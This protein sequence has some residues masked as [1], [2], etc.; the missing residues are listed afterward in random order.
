MSTIPQKRE[1]STEKVAAAQ[2]SP[3]WLL[4]GASLRNMF[5]ELRV[6]KS[7]PGS[8]LMAN[9]T[10]A[11]EMFRKRG[12]RALLIILSIFIGVSAVMV[13]I[14]W[15]QGL[16]ASLTNQLLGLG[17]NVITV[18]PGTPNTG[19][20][21]NISRP[22][23]PSDAQS[24]QALPHVMEVSPIITVPSVQVIYGNRNWNTDTE[25]V[26]PDFQVIQ[27]WQAG[28]GAWFGPLE[29]D[30][31]EAVAV[32]G[33]TV[34]HQLFTVP[35]SN[36]IGQQ[37]RIRDRP[38]RVIGILASKGA[39]ASQD[40]V[41]FVPFHTALTYLRN[42]NTVDHIE[43]Q[44]DTIDNIDQV[45]QGITA[46][47]R[48]NHHIAQGRADDFTIVTAGD[49]IQS[50]QQQ[51]QLMTALSIGIAAISL[52]IAGFGIT[53]TMFVAVKERTREIGIRMSIGARRRNIRNQ[54]LI[55]ALAV[56]L[57]GGLAGLLLGLL[58]G[59]IVTFVNR[60]PFV[61]TPTTVLLPFAISSALALIFGLYPARRA[62][63]L[64]PINAI[65]SSF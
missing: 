53:N 58:I 50:T 65:R 10:D 48:Q 15:T 60:L 17:A 16:S 45:Q 64:D 7:K 6:R 32:L 43:I 5:Q 12:T 26:S 47:L 51:T 61:V 59:W 63:R 29:D 54:F 37:I 24:L 38:F 36:P 13:V 1:P 18:D 34:A 3:S 21:T 14:I 52:T 9:V 2:A 35:G 4:Q 11:I 30:R 28:S 22:L 31:R 41:I 57:V 42:T 8:V 23:T 40:D 55:E 20:G 27:N 44:I 19:G 62:S 46:A 33:A 49:L 25:G 56:C 39:S